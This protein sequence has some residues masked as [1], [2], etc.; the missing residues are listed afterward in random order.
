MHAMIIVL[1]ERYVDATVSS[2]NELARVVSWFASRYD[3]HFIEQKQTF[4]IQN[5]YAQVVVQVH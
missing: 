4:E 5:K 3:V 2:S 1:N